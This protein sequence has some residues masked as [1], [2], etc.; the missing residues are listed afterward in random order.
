MSDAGTVPSL[1]CVTTNAG[2]SLY[3]RPNESGINAAN[4][5]F[6]Q[7]TILDAL[8]TEKGPR[9]R[10]FFPPALCSRL[11]TGYPLLFNYLGVN[12]LERIAR[13]ESERV[14]GLIEQQYYKSVTFDEM[15]ACEHEFA[16]EVDKLTMDSPAPLQLEAG[17][18]YP[19]PVPGVKKTEY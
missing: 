2:A 10:P 19:I 17:G 8:R 3:D 15:L 7:R 12:E 9:G 5:T 6:H 13:T 14:A 1:N 16:P 11:A 18:M 4:A